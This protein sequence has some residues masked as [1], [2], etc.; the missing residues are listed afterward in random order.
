[1]IGLEVIGEPGKIS[2]RG[3]FD[4]DFNFGQRLAG[5]ESP[6]LVRNSAGRGNSECEGRKRFTTSSN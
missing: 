1:M 5:G 4:F 3:D 6:C 2:M